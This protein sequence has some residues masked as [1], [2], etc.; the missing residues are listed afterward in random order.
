MYIE[1]THTDEDGNEITEN[2]PAKYSV[3]S[4][5]GGHGTHLNPS[6][7]EHAY[8]LEEF[9]N[10]FSDEEKEA[11]FT[12]GGMYDVNCIVCHGDRVERVPDWDAVW[13]GDLKERYQSFLKEEAEYE[14]L[15][16]SERLMGA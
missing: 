1:F 15:C 10:E 11:Y 12:R 6:I 13:P 9:D 2:I 4:R 14:Q 3:C 16:R 7:G 5:C 8:S